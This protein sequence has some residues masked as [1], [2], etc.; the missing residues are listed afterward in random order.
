MEALV[1]FLKSLLTYADINSGAIRVA[2]AYYKL[3]VKV[4]FDFNAYSTQ[5][6]VFNALDQFK[7]SKARSPKANVA[8]ALKS[9]QRL[10]LN[11]KNGDRPDAKNYV[12]LITDLEANAKKNLVKTNSQILKDTGAEI[13]TVGVGI[14]DSTELRTIASEPPGLHSFFADDYSALRGIT[15]NI[16]RMVPPRKFLSKISCMPLFNLVERSCTY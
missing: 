13:F 16:L 2:L 9:L 5:A 3:N 7:E 15:S 8:G 4:D 11:E 12:I 10:L 1:N 6:D 14:P